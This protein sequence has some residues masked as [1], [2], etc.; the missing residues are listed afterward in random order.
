MKKI[1]VTGGNSR[2]ALEL[3]KIKTKYNFIFLD[4]KKTKY[5]FT[6]FNK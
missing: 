5:T 3:K 4:K 6:F 2:F 1:L